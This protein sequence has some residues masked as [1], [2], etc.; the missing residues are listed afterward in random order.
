MKKIIPLLVLIL[1]A[2]C[3]SRKARTYILFKDL[4]IPPLYD[5]YFQRFTSIVFNKQINSKV[6]LRIA[7]PETGDLSILPDTTFYDMAVRGSLYKNEYSRVSS[8]YNELGLCTSQD[9]F[10]VKTYHL[11]YS[12]SYDPI[13]STLR[14]SFSLNGSLLPNTMSFMFDSSGYLNQ[15]TGS[16]FREP[17]DCIFL[18]DSE[19][20]LKQSLL[21]FKSKAD[22]A[23]VARDWVPGSYHIR[24]HVICNYFYN[25]NKIDSVVTKTQFYGQADSATEITFV[26]TA[27]L[28]VKTVSFDSPTGPRTTIFYQ[29]VR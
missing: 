13:K 3:T 2:S 16:D 17:V 18:Y 21:S 7:K 28:A 25:N 14:C 15:I 19:K 24:E 9:V 27:G 10:D 11:K 6:S 29:Y 8:L 4:K 22:S 5:S 12:Y 23:L 26:D 20:K 1:S